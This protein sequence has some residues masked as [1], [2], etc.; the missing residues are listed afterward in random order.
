MDLFCFL[1]FD[2]NE[3]GRSAAVNIALTGLQTLY[4]A[5]KAKTD[6]YVLEL[7]ALLHHLISLVKQRD[8]G[9]KPQTFRSPFHS[10]MQR[11]FLSLN[12][13]TKPRK[14]ELSEQDRK[15]LSKV[16]GRRLVPGI[17]KSQE[18]PLGKNKRIKVWALSRS[19]GN[20]PDRARKSCKHSK[21]NI[22]DV[23]DGL[24]LAT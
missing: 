21:T 20:S 18:F 12:S 23:M 8:H 9:S 13:G 16:S 11:Q 14:V 5:D 3:F 15:L 7:V 24:D 2:S 1:V 10:K 17:S 19:A 4:H 6:A 22:L